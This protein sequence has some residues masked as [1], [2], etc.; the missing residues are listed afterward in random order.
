MVGLAALC[1]ASMAGAKEPVLRLGHYSSG[2]GLTGFVLDR[3]GSPVKL[4]V[5][6]GEVQALTPTPSAVGNATRL[7]NGLGRAVVEIDEWGGVR[8]YATGP[9]DGTQVYR[10]GDAK[11]LPDP[12]PAPVVTAATLGEATATIRSKCNTEVAFEVDMA[13]LGSDAEAQRN[14][15]WQVARAVDVLTG[16]CRDDVGKKAVQAKLGRVRIKSVPAKKSV[17]HQGNVLVLEQP[18]ATTKGATLRDIQTVLDKWL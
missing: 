2:D 11:A 18:L 13:S 3:S 10:D 9:V 6:G 14:A 5:D 17:D 16:E 8:W 1:V 4:K 7:E 12:P 15:Q